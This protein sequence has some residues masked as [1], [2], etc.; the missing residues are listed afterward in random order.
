M[1]GQQQQAGV[2]VLKDR[3]V[4]S[5][6]AQSKYSSPVLSLS[7]RLSGTLLGC[8]ASRVFVL[9]RTKLL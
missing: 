8:L 5:P 1:V 2:K 6:P 9:W 3:P 7:H 4:T